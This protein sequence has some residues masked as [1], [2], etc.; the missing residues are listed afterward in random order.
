MK[1][2][3]PIVQEVIENFQT[4]ELMSKIFTSTETPSATRGLLISGDAGMGKTY[5][6]MEGL[7]QGTHE[8]NIE[9]VKG[10]SISAA[11]MYV[12]LYL[13]REQGKVLV[14]DDV[15]LIHKSVGELMTI[16][17]LLKGATEMTSGERIIG[18]ERVTQVGLFKELGIPSSFDFQGSVVWIT[19]DKIEDIAKKLKGHWPAISSRFTQ[20]P[21]RLEDY[22]KLQYSLYLVEEEGMLTHRCQVKEGGYSEDIVQMTLEYVRDNYRVLKEVSPRNFIKIADTIETYPN[23]WKMLCDNSLISK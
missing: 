19:N 16:V 7:Y 5:Y 20:I 12:K 10:S 13:C 4:V 11:A 3:N 23:H 15:D 18:W 17:D 9:Y 21:I 14:L 1:H 6:T 22:Q 8:S 2:K